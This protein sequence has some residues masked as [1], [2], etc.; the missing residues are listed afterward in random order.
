MLQRID[1]NQLGTMIWGRTLG[2][3]AENA[4]PAADEQG[5]IAQQQSVMDYSVADAAAVITARITTRILITLLTSQ[6][7]GSRHGSSAWGWT[8]VNSEWT[9]KTHVLIPRDVR[10][11]RNGDLWLGA[12]SRRAVEQCHGQPSGIILGATY[13]QSNAG[14]ARI[15]KSRRN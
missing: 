11:V 15:R 5:T 8:I 10:G 7:T 12:I 4:S 3:A 13:V 14:N 1:R 2:V 6:R 9:G